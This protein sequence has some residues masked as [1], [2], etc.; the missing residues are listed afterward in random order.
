VAELDRPPP[1]ISVCIV[2]GRRIALLDAVLRCLTAQVGAPAWELLVC[3]DG[4][5]DVAAT[6]RRH[7]P[8]ARICQVASALPGA[9]RNLL[10]AEAR[11]E[12][13]VFLD[14]DITFGSDLLARYARLAVIHPDVGVLGGPNDSP[15]TSTRFQFV[16][17]AVLAS[18]VGSGPVR[19]RYGAHPAGMAGDEAF[20]L[21]NLAVRRS[22]MVPFPADLV[23]AEENAVLD[24]LRRRQVRMYYD[25]GL[26]VFH[27][28]RITPRGFAQQMH[29]Y[30]RGRG[31][32]LRRHPSTLR[33]AYAA[34]T[35][36][37]AYVAALPAL[38]LAAGTVALVPLALYTAAVVVMAAW[39]A[40]TLRRPAELPLAAA[41]IVVLHACYGTG[42]ARGWLPR[43]V[44]VAEPVALWWS[45]PHDPAPTTGAP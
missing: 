39:I 35:V 5:P 7:V 13:L 45:D 44:E 9:A 23:C 43:V 8:D 34:P 29:K 11:G 17:G 30:G 41:M 24:E 1:T 25:P 10:V 21:C 27:E 28:R 37:L 15:P 18:V 42:V 12:L 16:Q 4:D 20:I 2:T 32:L 19:R 33:P 3:S 38:V 22:V 36:L 6:V 14:D 31:Q 40:R 26:V